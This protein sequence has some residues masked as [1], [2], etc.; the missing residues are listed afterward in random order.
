MPVVCCFKTAECIIMQMSGHGRSFLG[1]SLLS[2]RLGGRALAVV[3]EERHGDDQ[4]TNR[5]LIPAATIDPVR[6][7]R[8]EAE[9][10]PV[11]G[12]NGG[13]QHQIRWQEQ[14]ESWQRPSLSRARVVLQSHMSLRAGPNENRRP[15]LTCCRRV[16][17]GR[18][19]EWPPLLAL[20]GQ[21]RTDVAVS[22]TIYAAAQTSRMDEWMPGRMEA[23][24]HSWMHGRQKYIFRPAAVP[25]VPSG[26][27]PRHLLCSAAEMPS[28]IDGLS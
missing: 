17:G 20:Y 7:S 10:G 27:R 8:L 18:T 23:C 5:K 28:R 24:H 14:D 19:R 25:C 1:A 26:H 13:T 4:S 22:A 6:S 3:A 12:G 21:T 15:E 11:A 2:D 9:V 16:G